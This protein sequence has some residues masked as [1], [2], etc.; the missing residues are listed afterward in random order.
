MDVNNVALTMDKTSTNI[1]PESDKTSFKVHIKNSILENKASSDIAAK[2]HKS[3]SR[4]GH[5]KRNE[6]IPQMQILERSVHDILDCLDGIDNRIQR[7]V[8]EKLNIAFNS[9]STT[10][11]KTIDDALA[12]KAVSS[13]EKLQPSSTSCSYVENSL[14]VK[15]INSDK[16]SKKNQIKLNFPNI[17]VNGNNSPNN[18]ND[19]EMNLTEDYSTQDKNFPSL[20]VKKSKIVPQES[21]TKMPSAPKYKPKPIIGHCVNQKNLRSNL[22]KKNLKDYKIFKGKEPNQSII[23]PNTK[24][25]RD[26]T[27]EILKKSEINYFTY[28]AEEEKCTPLILKGVSPDFDLEDIK[29]EFSNM[30]LLT[31]IDKISP[32][33]GENIKRFNYYILRIKPG[34]QLGEFLNINYLL[35]TRVYIEKLNKTGTVQCF[36]CQSLEHVA[37]N[38]QMDPKCVKCSEKHLSFECTLAKNSP[39]DTLKC[40]LCG[41]KG[42]PAS[43][44]GCPNVV[45]LIKNKNANKTM[46]SPKKIT[47]PS[48][49]EE[50][51]SFANA[52]SSG[53]SQKNTNMS[54]I[55]NILNKASNELFGCEFNTLRVHFDEFMRTYLGPGDILVKREAMLNFMMSSNFYGC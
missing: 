6:I 16:V 39:P 13:K 52:L 10:I 49:V 14:K 1:S 11:T 18:P 4:S 20:S 15:S 21:K 35:N 37:S 36:R 48:F 27:I 44:R 45:E 23:I 7:I 34:V 9:L 51:L 22:E 40:A 43:Y 8:S 38:C 26:A 46:N 24:E 54:G 28:T 50:N 19:E 17:S 5:R 30:E 31:K 25:V 2:S 53:S 29:N 33:K 41:Q 47:K 55:K 12:A 32:M 3:R 42:H